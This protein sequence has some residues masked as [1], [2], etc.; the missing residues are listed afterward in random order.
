MDNASD[1]LILWAKRGIAA[2][3]GPFHPL[4]CHMIDVAEVAK[5]LWTDVRSP[6]TKR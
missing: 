1:P 6:A 2:P 4:I 3:D 5:A